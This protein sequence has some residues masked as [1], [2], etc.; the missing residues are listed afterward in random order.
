M[1]KKHKV[2]ILVDYPVNSHVCRVANDEAMYIV[3][4]YLVSMDN[5]LYECRGADGVEY[6]FSIEI[7]PFS[8][9]EIIGFVKKNKMN[10]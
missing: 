10:Q 8:Q 3:T 1:A 5:I 6:L 4:G 2:N 7:K 9:T